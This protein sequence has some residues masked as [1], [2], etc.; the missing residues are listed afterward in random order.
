MS[1]KVIQFVV[2]F[3]GILIILAFLALIYGMYLKIS[4]S[5]AY[6]KLEPYIYSLNLKNDE[7]IMDIQVINKYRLLVLIEG[8]GGI[9]GGIY[10]IETNKIIGFIEK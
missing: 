3:L 8:S 9:K 6:S 10:D 5:S 1:K 7:K 4:T 2:I